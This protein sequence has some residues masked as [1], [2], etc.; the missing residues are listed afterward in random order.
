M[1][2][3]AVH[4]LP[5]Q[6]IY[7]YHSRH[8]AIELLVRNLRVS[9]DAFGDLGLLAVAGT[10]I[11]MWHW[12]QGTRRQNVALLLTA[13]F[14]SWSLW[15][16]FVPAQVADNSYEMMLAVPAVSIC[17]GLAFLFICYELLTNPV[18]RAGL[19]IVLLLP[20]GTYVWRT[21]QAKDPQTA[22]AFEHDV[23][24]GTEANAIVLAPNPDMCTI[25]YSHRHVIRAVHTDA[26]AK[27]ALQHLDD[28]FPDQPIYIAV[29]PPLTPQFQ[30]SIGAFR[31]VAQTSNLLLLRVG[32]AGTG[33]MAAAAATMP[34]PSH[35]VAPQ[36]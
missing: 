2:R 22:F 26:V 14:G 21:A 23:Q 36:W 8:T 15:L 34:G 33:R 31:T 1:H 12:L 5:Y 6:L 27:F 24:T 25:Y 29:P 20:L 13:S 10:L 11:A 30:H 19:V 16:L 28:I 32:T 3:M 9:L 35:W 7:T 18:C 4:D 17:I